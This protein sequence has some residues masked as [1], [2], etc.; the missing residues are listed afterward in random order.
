VSTIFR[1]KSENISYATRSSFIKQ[2]KS[3]NEEAWMNFYSKYVGMIHSIGRKHNLTKEEC[4]DLMVEVMLIFWKKLDNFFYDRSKGRFR[5]FLSRIS[6]I[7]AIKIYKKSRR[8]YQT[9]EIQ[10]LEYPAEVDEKYMQEYQDFLLDKALEDLKE[11]VDTE[12][13]EVFYMSVF[14]SR[15]VNEIALVTRKSPGNI[16]A[17]RHRCLKKLKELINFYRQYEENNLAPQ[18]KSNS[19]SEG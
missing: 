14:Q 5:S 3:G 12:T 8:Q 17:I 19:V 10:D 2:I 15:P 13:Y 9:D 7:A 16:Y 11:L 1:L 4:D 18:F 6:D